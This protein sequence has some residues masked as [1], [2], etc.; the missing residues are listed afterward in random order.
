MSMREL[1]NNL[2]DMFKSCF[3]L[4]DLVELVFALCSIILPLGNHLYMAMYT[5]VF[6]N[7][8]SMRF[9]CLLIMLTCLQLNNVCLVFILCTNQL[10]CLRY[11]M[12]HIFSVMCLCYDCKF[13]SRSFNFV[14][15]TLNH[16]LQVTTELIL[17]DRNHP[18]VVMWSLANEPNTELKE[19]EDYFQSVKL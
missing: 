11:G 7:M 13:L 17:R 9:N 3:N 8:Y 6:I 4:S 19:S 1:C 14:N 15:A 16:H 12:L 2:F 10:H 5:Y 18:S